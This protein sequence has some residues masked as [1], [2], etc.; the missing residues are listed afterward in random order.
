MTMRIMAMPIMITRTHTIITT[1]MP[2]TRTTIMRI[3][4]MPTANHGHASPRP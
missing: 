2:R 1:I 3:M 4:I